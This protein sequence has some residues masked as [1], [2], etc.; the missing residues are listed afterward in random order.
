M[1]W[2]CVHNTVSRQKP[3]AGSVCCASVESYWTESIYSP[4]LSLSVS[5]KV[6]IFQNRVWERRTAKLLNSHLRL[7]REE[8]PIETIDE[9]SEIA[10]VEPPLV[11]A[12]VELTR[13]Y[14]GVL[15]AGIYNRPFRAVHAVSSISGQPK[16]KVLAKLLSESW[17]TDALAG[18]LDGWRDG[19]SDP[20]M[21]WRTQYWHVMRSMLYRRKIGVSEQGRLIVVPD[22]CEVGDSL[23]FLDGCR[24]VYVLRPQH[25]T[26]KS[27][28]VLIGDAYMEGNLGF[29]PTDG[30]AAVESHSFRTVENEKWLP[31]VGGPGSKV[32]EIW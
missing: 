1:E 13:R 31:N 14:A 23:A 7:L 4:T 21:G 29:P 6:A 5:R 24:G 16:G 30:P 10:S 9:L 18:Y 12:Y 22:V 19:P 15:C 32:L 27:G 8:D 3:E 20:A 26:D 11:D 28:W 17:R 2:D 25:D